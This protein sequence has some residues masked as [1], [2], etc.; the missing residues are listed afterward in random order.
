[1]CRDLCHC[2]AVKVERW[3]SSWTEGCQNENGPDSTNSQK[4]LWR[5]Q[6]HT[7][8][9]TCCMLMLRT[10]YHARIPL[11]PKVWKG[12]VFPL[13]FSK[14]SPLAQIPRPYCSRSALA[15]QLCQP[16]HWKQDTGP[17]SNQP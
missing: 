1:V 9:Q 15:T 4:I 2:M 13:F 5:L 11:S 8:R 3:M 16:Q 12:S 6:M 7:T 10:C 14:N 17:S